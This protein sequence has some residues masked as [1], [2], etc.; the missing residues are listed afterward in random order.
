MKRHNLNDAIL[1]FSQTQDFWEVFQ[2]AFD[3]KGSLDNHVDPLAN[4]SI[5]LGDLTR[6][7][8]NWLS[9]KARYKWEFNTGAVAGQNSAIELQN[10]AGSNKLFVVSWVASAR[11][12]AVTTWS[13]WTDS[14]APAG[15]LN[16]RVQRLDTRQET[17]G[18]GVTQ[19]LAVTNILTAAF[20][21]PLVANQVSGS[22]SCAALG[23]NESNSYLVLTPGQ[24]MVLHNGTVNQAFD[25]TVI[26]SERDAASPELSR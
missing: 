1:Y 8:Y 16:L 21:A 23:V 3:V 25:F 10:P 24:R 19:Q 22:T 17:F 13:W 14:V 5:Q 9:R 18:I 7:E 26:W 20:A 4:L 15:A 12:A 2:R 11:A 6:V